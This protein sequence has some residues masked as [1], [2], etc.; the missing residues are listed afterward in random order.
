[1]PRLHLFG[2][3][4]RDYMETFLGAGCSNRLGSVVIT[5]TSATSDQDT[6]SKGFQPESLSCEHTLTGSDLLHFLVYRALHAFQG[7]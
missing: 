5:D 1:M 3:P 4:T 2:H 6:M 7:E